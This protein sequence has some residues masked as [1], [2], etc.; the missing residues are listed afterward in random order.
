MPCVAMLVLLVPGIDSRIAFL[1]RLSIPQSEMR[2]LHGVAWYVL[3]E[4][5]RFTISIHLKELEA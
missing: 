4:A 2:K 1:F 3:R 5:T